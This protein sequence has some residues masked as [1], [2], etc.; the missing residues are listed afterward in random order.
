MK[1]EKFDFDKLKKGLMEELFY[2]S[3]A[4]FAVCLIGHPFDTI[5]TRM[6]IN[7]ETVKNTVLKLIKKDGLKSFYKGLSSPLY[8]I[9]LINSIVFGVYASTKNLLEINQK[10][11]KFTE[12]KIIL[13][14][15]M[16]AGVISSSIS[17]PMELFKTKMQIQTE[18]KYYKSNLDIIKKIK[19]VSG[20]RGIFQ[21]TS[22]TILRDSI[23]YPS[24][25]L[26][27]EYML[28]YF[29]NQTGKEKLSS[30]YF[31]I[32][33]ACSGIVCWLSC[34][35]LDV[36]KS[37]VQSEIIN[38]PLSI[39]PNGNFFREFIYIYKNFGVRGYFIG[40]APVIGKATLASSTG[41]M[42]WESSKI[43]FENRF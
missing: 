34:F 31:M 41:F 2:G 23:A 22:L 35:G 14:S 25:F 42:V 10:E 26:T 33:G 38:K 13:I 16:L 27:Y 21:G 19:K 8:S 15:S 32:S 6:Q 43:F 40:L 11:L 5:K 37:R 12:N 20:I 29:R 7:N 24:L 18:N 39:I 9:P 4:G 1:L 3:I 17:G 28:K 30:L 36:I